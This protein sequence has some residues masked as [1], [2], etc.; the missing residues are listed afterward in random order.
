MKKPKKQTPLKEDMG[1]TLLDLGKLIFGGV[2]IGG[3]LRVEIPHG[4][5][6]IGGIVAAVA[7]ISIGL[8]LGKKKKK[9]SN[10]LQKRGK[11]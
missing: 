11:K 8:L 3:I 5:L 1:K 9:K 7:L 2:F 10:S 6:I 4:I